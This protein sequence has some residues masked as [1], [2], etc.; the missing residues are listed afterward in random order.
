M[1]TKG[2]GIQGHL[3]SYTDRGQPRL[4]DPVSKKTNKTL[5]LTTKSYK[6]KAVLTYKNYNQHV[7]FNIQ[8]IQFISYHNK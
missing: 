7:M 4:Q 3:Q 2:P 6:V 5:P 1:K 8:N